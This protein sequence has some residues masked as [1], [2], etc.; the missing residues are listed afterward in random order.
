MAKEKEEVWKDIPDWDLY[1]A[2]SLGRI[3]SWKGISDEPKILSLAYNIHG[4]L[5]VRL[6]QEGKPRMFLVHQ[7]VAMAFLGHE[8]NLHSIVVDHINS[9]R[10]DNRPENLQLLSDRENC[11]KGWKDKGKGQ[12]PGIDKNKYG[13]RARIRLDNKTHYLGRFPTKEEAIEAREKKYQ[14][15]LL[16]G[17][18]ARRY[19]RRDL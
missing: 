10:D 9:V 6:S 17:G 8:P 3:R 1:E 14:E 2:S 13:W 15:F 11:I 5:R 19:E 16:V 18:D 4:Y 7:L 12:T